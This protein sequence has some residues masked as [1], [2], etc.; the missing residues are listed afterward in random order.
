MQNMAE[1]WMVLALTVALGFITVVDQPAHHAFVEEMVGRDRLS[2]AVAL[3]SAVLNSAR[4][5]GPAIAG[6]LIAS[7]GESW[8]FF[9]NAVSF[10]AVVGALLAMR[11]HELRRP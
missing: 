9:V 3:N 5:T 2:N 6:L 4:I 7:V 8:V 1:A 11:P 10:V